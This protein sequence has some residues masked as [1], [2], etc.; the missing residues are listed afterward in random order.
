MLACCLQ[1]GGAVIPAVNL[2]SNIGFGSRAAHRSDRRHPAANLPTAPMAFPLCHP[3]AVVA[4]RRADEH[5]A[6]VFRS[7][8]YRKARTLA[9][10]L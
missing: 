4:D 9:F 5:T 10:R 8:P 7:S 1:R 3:T 6:A 2:V